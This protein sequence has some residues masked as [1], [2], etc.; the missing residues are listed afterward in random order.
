M[1]ENHTC[2]KNTNIKTRH[3]G[4]GLGIKIVHVQMTHFSNFV[5]KDGSAR[6]GVGPYDCNYRFTRLQL[7]YGIRHLLAVP[8]VHHLRNQMKTSCNGKH[9]WFIVSCLV[10]SI[11]LY[12]Y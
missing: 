12:R 11:K 7:Q 10:G 5:G 1:P 4:K 6:L 9:E 8:S 2:S 3:A